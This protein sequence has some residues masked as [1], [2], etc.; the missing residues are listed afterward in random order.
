MI[1]I[2]PRN[3]YIFSWYNIKGHRYFYRVRIWRNKMCKIIETTEN[4]IIWIIFRICL[5]LDLFLLIRHPSRLSFRF[6]ANCELF[7]PYKTKESKQ[8]VLNNNIFDG[9]W[10]Q[11]LNYI[12]IPVYH[13]PH[14][15]STK[16]P[17]VYNNSYYEC[18]SDLC[19]IL[20]ESVRFYLNVC[21]I[22]GRFEILCY[23][24]NSHCNRQR[25]GSVFWGSLN[26]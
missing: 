1:S 13:K 23:N 8:I 14:Y 4:I 10:I 11:Y 22:F 17:I 7:V 15:V 25:V 2:W 9:L 19:F 24:I 26:R 18:Q 20:F 12:L 16:G 21:I 3:I 6:S 5:K